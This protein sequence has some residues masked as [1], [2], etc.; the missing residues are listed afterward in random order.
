MSRVGTSYVELFHR[1]WGHHGSLCRA[2]VRL[3]LPKRARK[4]ARPMAAQVQDL[5]PSGLLDRTLFVGGQ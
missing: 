1:A 2:Y 4:V 3:E 5:R